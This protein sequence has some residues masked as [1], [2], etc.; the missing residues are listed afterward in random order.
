M[1]QK[2]AHF[3]ATYNTQCP[4]SVVS[5]HVHCV[6]HLCLACGQKKYA[7]QEKCASCTADP[8]VPDKLPVVQHSAPPS[9]VMSEAVV[10]FR[11]ISEGNRLRVR[12][13]T[14]GY[15]PHI[16]CQFPKGLCLTL[17]SLFSSFSSHIRIFSTTQ[18]YELK[19]GSTGHQPQQ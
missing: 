6:E 1:P 9:E 19:E 12:V 4:N 17:L 14:P 5:G 18:P 16:N 10:T 2:C 11:C 15:N 8:P 3:S 13:T 7:F